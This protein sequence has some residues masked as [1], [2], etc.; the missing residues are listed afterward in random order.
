MFESNL[1]D[2]QEYDL[3]IESK[4][5][6]TKIHKTSKHQKKDL[7]QEITEGITRF[8]SGKDLYEVYDIVDFEGKSKVDMMYYGQLFKKIEETEQLESVQNLLIS[9]TKSVKTVYEITN[10]KPELYGRGIDYSILEASEEEVSSKISKRIYEFLDTHFYKLTN[11]KRK[12]KYFNESI[13]ISKKLIME[14]VDTEEAIEYA[15]KSIVMEGFLSKVAFPFS[16]QSRI[17]YLTECKMYARV[18]DQDRL[19]EAVEDAQK[20][21]RG[22]S[23]IIAAVI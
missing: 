9:L 16:I 6:I 13:V 14:G 10:L 18:F 12:E 20:N 15:I 17:N 8:D 11:E 23:K 3:M 22:I 21:I 7:F 2:D 1:T 19:I 5:A 4:Q